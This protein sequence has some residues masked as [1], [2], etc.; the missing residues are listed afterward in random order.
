MIWID[1]L[2]SEL[3][4]CVCRLLQG[5]RA[6]QIHRQKGN[7]DA[8]KG[9]D[10]GSVLGVAG[11]VVFLSAH[12]QHVA[13]VTPIGM[14]F[15]LFGYRVVPGTASMAI[16]STSVFSPLESVFTLI[17][18]QRFRNRPWSQGQ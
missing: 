9:A 18:P 1:N 5:H 15:G 11:D 4:D 8:R 10:F 12:R 17:L 14:K 6:R 7:V 3:P 13:V 2:R 16:F